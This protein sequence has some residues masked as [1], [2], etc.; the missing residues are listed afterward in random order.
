MVRAKCLS[1]EDDSARCAEND[2]GNLCHVSA[3]AGR[4]GS[5]EFGQERGKRETDE[6][7]RAE[8]PLCVLHTRWYGTAR[9]R[10][11]A[12]ALHSKCTHLDR[13]KFAVKHRPLIIAAWITS[14]ALA[15]TGGAVAA[16]TITGSSIE[17]GTLTSVD[18][19]NSTLVPADL[20][21]AVREDLREPVV[22]RIEV[23]ENERVTDHVGN[24]DVKC[25][26]GMIAVNGGL[27]Q[28]VSGEEAPAA[29]SDLPLNGGWRVNYLA[30]DPSIPVRV[31]AVCV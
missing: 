25:P 29:W 16:D 4:Q 7:Q 18:V 23:P 20:A 14:L 13:K 30:A 15:S 1:G 22:V 6:G 26:A 10:R 2:E 28:D 11:L 12:D 17:N 9:A 21:P 27:D 8:V 3:D 31:F 5:R 19:K 24:I